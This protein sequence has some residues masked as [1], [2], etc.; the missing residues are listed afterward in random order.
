MRR[1]GRLLLVLFA[2]GVTISPTLVEGSPEFAYN[3]TRPKSAL[4]VLQ[5]IFRPR[6]RPG[7]TRG[8][9]C[10]ITPGLRP[11]W[12]SLSDTPFIL[13][14]RPL[15][16]WE[17]PVARVEVRLASTKAVVWQQT[18]PPQSQRI[19]YQGLLLQAGQTYQVVAFGRSNYSLNTGEGAQFTVVN[20]NQRNEIIQKL[21]AMEAELK[22]QNLSVEAI[23]IAKAT[24]LSRRSLLSDAYQLLDSLP[25]QSPEL[26]AFLTKLSAQV[27]GD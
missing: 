20:A 10:L 24:E 5:G 14:D 19:L 8:P 22:N 1:F 4:E 6:R 2:S 23:A 9:I 17:R 27:C 7:G 26:N 11:E 18:L 15:L 16:V 3:Q 21:A 12:L 25:E 13:S